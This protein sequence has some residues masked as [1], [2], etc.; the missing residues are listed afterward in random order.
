[1]LQFAFSRWTITYKYCPFSCVIGKRVGQDGQL[2]PKPMTPLVSVEVYLCI[3]LTALIQSHRYWQA[4][5]NWTLT[6]D[7]GHVLTS[8]FH[9]DNFL[10]FF[11]LQ[12]HFPT[13]TFFLRNKFLRRQF[14]FEPFSYTTYFLRAHFLTT[15]FSYWVHFL[16]SS[17]CCPINTAVNINFISYHIWINASQESR[18][19]GTYRNAFLHYSQY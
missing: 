12:W 2:W 13:D 17:W 5:N 15:E 1:M 19:K 11:P 4:I 18:T 16:P 3:F 14:T 7:L 6:R 10:H 8:N 9:P